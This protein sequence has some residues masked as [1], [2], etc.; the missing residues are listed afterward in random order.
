[1]CEDTSSETY[2][3]EPADAMQRN[4][5]CLETRSDGPGPWDGFSDF[6]AY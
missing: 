1:M 4:N 3:E 2:G 5:Y 6:S